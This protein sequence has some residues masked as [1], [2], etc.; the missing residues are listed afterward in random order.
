[1]PHISRFQLQDSA[2]SGFT[3]KKISLVKDVGLLVG[4]DEK[5]TPPPSKRS[6][7]GEGESSGDP[8]LT[9]GFTVAGIATPSGLDNPVVYVTTAGITAT[10]THP[11]MR[12]AGSNSAIDITA[13]PQVTRGTQSQ[14]LTLECVGS[15][16]TLDH[17]NGLNLMGSTRFVMQS[18]ATISL[19]YQSGATVWS[20]VSRTPFGGI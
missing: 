11:W 2:R 14:V 5:D 17:G 12:V 1:M 7:G 18:G 13:N 4:G 10:F 20:E 6:L 8:R 16:I 19:M 9:T 15:A 3:Q